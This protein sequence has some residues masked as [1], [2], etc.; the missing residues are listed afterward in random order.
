M[1]WSRGGKSIKFTKWQYQ[2]ATARSWDRIYILYTEVNT[3][4]T[5][6]DT[7]AAPKSLFCQS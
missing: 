2:A 4:M 3:K 7:K 1:L 5:A 6:G